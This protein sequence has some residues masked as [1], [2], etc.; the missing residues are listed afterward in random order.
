MIVPLTPPASLDAVAR[1]L[2]LV[3]EMPCRRDRPTPGDLQGSYDVWFDGGACRYL[4]SVNAFDFVDGSSAWLS[5]VSPRL[6]GGL[7]LA[8]GESVSFSQDAPRDDICVVC[9]GALTAGGTFKQTPLG[10]AHVGC[11]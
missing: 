10:P 1:I 2:R 11:G 9:R 3:A 4:T 8:S 7:T 5:T 6:K